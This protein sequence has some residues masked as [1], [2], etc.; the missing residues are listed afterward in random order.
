MK[1][2]IWGFDLRLVQHA[3]VRLVGIA[4][5][6]QPAASPSAGVRCWRKR[7]RSIGDDENSRASARAA[8]RAGRP[9]ADGPFR[10]LEASE[11]GLESD[12]RRR[13]L[14]RMVPFRHS[15]IQVRG[16]MFGF[17]PMASPATSASATVRGDAGGRRICV[18]RTYVTPGAETMLS[19]RRVSGATRNGSA[20]PWMSAGFQFTTAVK[21]RVFSPTPPRQISKPAKTLERYQLLLIG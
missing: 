19:M 6:P 10:G 20:W 16:W 11:D 18:R 17:D 8:A 9:L 12:W 14:R 13:R 21:S 2:R 1:N 15:P 4:E 7:G 3:D 5:G